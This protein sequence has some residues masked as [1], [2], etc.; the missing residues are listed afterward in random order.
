M[1]SGSEETIG[2]RLREG[3][4]PLPV[5][6]Q[7]DV[8]SD[9]IAALQARLAIGIKRYGRPLQTF[10]GRDAHQDELEEFVDGWAYRRQARLERQALEAELA[11]LRSRLEIAEA[12]AAAAQER[13]DFLRAAGCARPRV[14][15]N[16]DPAGAPA[17]AVGAGACLWVLANSCRRAI[18]RHVAAGA[19][20]DRGLRIAAD[21][22]AFGGE[23]GCGAGCAP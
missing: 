16:P 12:K 23:V 3:D 20:R 7:R 6:G 8:I 22:E 18:E 17:G 9:L 5:D 4:Q 21:L 14:V 1:S 2:L 19:Q 15:G 10:N 11:A 13:V